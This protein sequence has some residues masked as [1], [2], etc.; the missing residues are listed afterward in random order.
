MLYLFGG[1]T[2]TDF[3]L[4]LLIGIVVG[5]YS[6]IFMAAPLAVT[7]EGLSARGAPAR[8]LRTQPALAEGARLGMARSAASGPTRRASDGR[9]RRPKKKAGKRR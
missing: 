3:A 9:R 5:T 4:A 7:L 8:P 2:L 1:E 6:S